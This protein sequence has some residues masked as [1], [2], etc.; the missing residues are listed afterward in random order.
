VNAGPCSFNRHESVGGIASICVGEQNDRTIL[1]ST[2]RREMAANSLSIKSR[3]PKLGAVQ[4]QQQIQP[5][6]D[7]N[8]R[9]APSF[10]FP[11]K[12]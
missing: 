1:A 2:K 11:A 5:T 3:V 7:Q 9:S 8:S 6:T 12:T 10:P 4:Q